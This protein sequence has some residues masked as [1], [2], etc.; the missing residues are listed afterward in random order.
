MEYFVFFL[1]YVSTAAREL[2]KDDLNELLAQCRE[3]NAKLGITGMLLYKDGNFMQ[4]LEGEETVVRSIYAKISGDPAATGHRGGAAVPGLVHGITEPGIAGCR[5]HPR[6]QRVLEHAPDRPGVLQKP[7]PS[8]EALALLQ[9]KHV[10][11]GFG[12][13][14]YAKDGF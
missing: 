3:N 14:K 13:L 7:R 2:S 4:V 12:P 5:L 10:N 1:T 6:L 9:E 11:R 8:S